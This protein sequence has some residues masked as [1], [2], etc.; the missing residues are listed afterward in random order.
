MRL[1]RQQ[2]RGG[3]PA[4]PTTEPLLSC[5]NCGHILPPMQS[6]THNQRPLL[7]T[8]LGSC[9]FGAAV[10][11]CPQCSEMATAL[12]SLCNCNFLAMPKSSNRPI[13]AKQPEPEPEPKPKS[14]GF[15]WQVFGGFAKGG[16]KFA[17]YCGL[18]MILL[19]KACGRPQAIMYK[20]GIKMVINNILLERQK[21]HLERSLKRRG[22]A[23][24]SWRRLNGFTIVTLAA[25]LHVHWNTLHRWES[26]GKVIP[27]EKLKLLIG[28]GFP[29]AD[30][31]VDMANQHKADE[32]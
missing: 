27:N 13:V 32:Q 9:A 16:A 19:Y 31:L 8:A 23:L 12:R 24:S 20:E 15:V 14:K 4:S 10:R 28:L 22:A 5:S 29:K 30:A 17:C 26:E 2:R 6:P 11:L 21:R 1:P 7:A 3:W 25:Q 18:F